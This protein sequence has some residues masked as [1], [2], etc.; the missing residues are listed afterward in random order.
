MGVLNVTPDSF[1]DGGDFYQAADAIAQGQML[2]A[3]GAAIIDIGGE[4]TGPGS[5]PC[6]ADK[7]W[8][9]IAPVVEAL[10]KN[11]QISVD[12]YKASVA[13][14]ALRSGARMINDIS[15]L[16]YDSEMA[17]VVRD[18]DAA[19]VL[20]FSKEAGSSPSVSEK[21]G[22]YTDVIV[23]I[24]KFFGERIAY[25]MANGIA[26]E[27]IVLDP[28]LGRYVSADA[29]YSWEILRRL[30]ELRREFAQFQFLI[31]A[32]RKGFLGGLLADRDPVSQLVGVHAAECGVDIIR[33]H[34]VRMALSFSK[35]WESISQV[36]RVDH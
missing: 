32:S 6:S 30:S 15:A 13:A 23:E 21:E 14:R 12:T 29:K 10:S 34:N 27:R 22:V 7:E 18:F 26:A 4:A 31:G 1:S 25:A 3:E 17:A 11:C 8:Q 20:M 33:T 2:A 16:R 28:G 35:V 9:R 19:V 5:V 36:R 24:S